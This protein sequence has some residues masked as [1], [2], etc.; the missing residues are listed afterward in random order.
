LLRDQLYT[1]WVET[2]PELEGGVEVEPIIP[3]IME[4]VAFFLE[5]KQAFLHPFCYWKLVSLTAEKVFI[6]YLS[7]FKSA[8]QAGAVFDSREITQIR[9]DIT[10]MKDGL[11]NA[12]EKSPSESDQYLKTAH[13]IVG[14]FAVLD[15]CCELFE[16]DIASQQL[17]TVMKQLVH[18]AERTPVDAA[19]MAGL[20]ETCLGLKGVLRYTAR[21]LHAS[22]TATPRASMASG[23]S[24]TDLIA[25]VSAGRPESTSLPSTPS[26][27][28]TPRRRS[29]F[30]SFF[31]REPSPEPIAFSHTALPRTQ[32]MRLPTKEEGALLAQRA[33]AMSDAEIA[34]EAQQYEEEKEQEMVRLA[35]EIRE[36]ALIDCFAL[37]IQDLRNHA[38][39]THATYTSLTQS[40]SLERVF[41]TDS[42]SEYPLEV[43]LLHSAHPP[44]SDHH[45]AAST[46]IGRLGGSLQRLFHSP[47][48]EW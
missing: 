47:K 9:E 16:C 22:R 33:M 46:R 5:G 3:T 36:Q 25:A 38:P 24:F 42:S 44:S 20:L 7:L 8:H 26:P 21:T 48:K 28:K 27:V 35:N 14:R 29:L 43:Q 40:S 4:D 19:G 31:V 10:A 23:S 13:A 34:A 12:L 39:V 6:L 11:L 15:S 18:T 1:T 45:R 32:S 2:L 41:G 37:M 30:G 17:D